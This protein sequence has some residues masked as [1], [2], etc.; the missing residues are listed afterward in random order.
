M[1]TRRT[2]GVG[3]L[4]GCLATI[5]C[6]GGGSSSGGGGSDGGHASSSTA[7]GSCKS[8][9]ACDVLPLADVN[10]ALGMSISMTKEADSVSAPVGTYA[11]EYGLEDPTNLFFGISCQTALKNGPVIY[12]TFEQGVGGMNTEV[13][14]LGSFAFWHTS[15]ADAGPPDGG[16]LYVF[17][18]DFG[19]LNF[20]IKTPDATLDA[21]TAAIQLANEVL[22]KL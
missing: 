1:T 17:F 11:C 6:S 9:V 21:Q 12:Q 2:L 3:T 10:A 5:G 13:S 16:T 18:G 22:P 8:Y 19:T 4:L 14:N 7:G 15:A 20:E